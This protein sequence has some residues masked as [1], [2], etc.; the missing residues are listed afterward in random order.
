MIET[1]VKNQ[2]VVFSFPQKKTL[3][4][5]SIV[6]FEILNGNIGRVRYHW[7]VLLKRN[8]VCHWFSRSGVRSPVG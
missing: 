7:I 5:V 8:N 3:I 2:L 1:Y 4:G 6:N